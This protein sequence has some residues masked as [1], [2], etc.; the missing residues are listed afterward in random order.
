MFKNSPL[1]L[2]W[3]KSRLGRFRF[4]T[5]KELVL[6]WNQFQQTGS[7]F[8]SNAKNQFKMNH[9]L[10]MILVKKG[11]MYEFMLMRDRQK[12]GLL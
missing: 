3:V 10:W 2:T 1:I 11:Y 12:L 7:L 6:L 8:L 9:W 5:S 4:Q